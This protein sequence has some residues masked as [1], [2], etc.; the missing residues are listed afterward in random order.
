VVTGWVVD[1]SMV[2]AWGFPDENSPAADRFWDQ[3]RTNVDL[4][5]PALWWFECTNALL[6]ARRRERIDE[7]QARRMSS[8]VAAL[9][10]TTTTAPVGDALLRLQALGLKHGVS[11]YDAAYLDL[12]RTLNTGLATFDRRLAAA[13]ADEGIPVWG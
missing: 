11:A 10:V 6:V 1:T 12:A 7:E 3:V 5:V 8:L 9:P 2:L 13:A 4:H